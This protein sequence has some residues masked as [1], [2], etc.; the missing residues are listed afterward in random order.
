MQLVYLL[1]FFA[2]FFIIFIIFDMFQYKKSKKVLTSRILPKFNIKHYFNVLIIFFLIYILYFNEISEMLSQEYYLLFF[3]YFLSAVF[4]LY[5]LIKKLE[6]LKIMA[7]FI[8][9]VL[10]VSLIILNFFAI[11]F[12]WVEEISIFTIIPTIFILQ[13][14]SS[15]VFFG[16]YILTQKRSKRTFATRKTNPYFL[17]FIDTSHKPIK[18]I[19]IFLFLTIILFVLQFLINVPWELNAIQTIGLVEVIS[20]NF[21]KNQVEQA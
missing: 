5:R 18:D 2:I 10:A 7:N 17:E 19:A 9:S 20:N 3:V 15:L 13:I 1:G 12:L 11:S 6:I 8:L 4:T 16:F 21:S 14:F